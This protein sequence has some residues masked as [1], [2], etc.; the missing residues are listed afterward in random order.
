MR[1]SGGECRDR[2]KLPETLC[3]NT[4]WPRAGNGGLEFKCLTVRKTPSIR[5]VMES[6]QISRTGRQHV[7]RPLRR[8]Q[9][10]KD[11]TSR[12]RRRGKH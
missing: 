11:K 6:L 12:V 3:P 10:G 5:N 9:K 8:R 4:E 2:R 1:G 7:K